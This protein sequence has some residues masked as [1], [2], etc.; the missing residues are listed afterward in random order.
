MTKWM[1][2]GAVVLLAVSCAK[3]NMTRSP[4][5]ME[6]RT[7]LFAM[8]G[9][10]GNNLGTHLAG[11]NEVPPRETQAQGEAIFRI[12]DDGTSVDYKLIASNIDNVFMA[13]IHLGAVGTN[14]PIVVWLYPSTAPV[15]GPLGAGRHDG[16]L[17]EGTF[18]AANMVGPLAGHDFA[19]LLTA[20]R[21]SGA[22]VNV[23]TNDGVAP[24]NTG[25][26]DFPGGEVRGWLDVPGR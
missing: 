20:M 23:H 14:G 26:G 5:P 13:H 22:Y 4:F 12:S 16:V 24:T 11:D 9:A 25:P 18:T 2:L 3:D 8:S 10:R 15:Q 19:E 7:P 21:S 17:S 1:M 6:V